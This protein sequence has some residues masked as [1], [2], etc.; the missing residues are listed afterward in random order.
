MGQL[1]AVL[2]LVAAAIH[3][4]IFVLEAVWWTSP[5][6]RAVF[7]TTETE[8]AA[9]R[10]LAFNQGFYNLFLAVIATVGAITL[11]S[12]ATTIGSTLLAAGCGSMLAAGLVLV[13]SDRT[14]TRPALVQLGAPLLALVALAISAR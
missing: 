9:T 1:A 12:G 3:A 14:K 6:G 2:A 4:Y 5:R 13:V 8:A 11:L 10:Q 7:G